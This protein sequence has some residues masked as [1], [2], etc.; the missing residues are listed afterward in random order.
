MPKARNTPDAA[1]PDASD[2]R[3]PRHALQGVLA[4]SSQVTYGHVGN[5]A[6]RFVLERMGLSAWAVPTV[7]LAQHPGHRGGGAQLPISAQ[8]I[9]GLMD[10]LSAAGRLAHCQGVIA[11]YLP[12]VDQARALGRALKLVHAQAPQA[13]VLFDP[14]FGDDGAWGGD[15][16]PKGSLYLPEE[17]PTLWLEE[18]LPQADYLTPNRFELSH[19]TGVEVLDPPTALRACLTLVE[20]MGRA[21]QP[22]LIA[23]TSVPAGQG[24][25]ATV[26]SQGPLEGFVRTPR[27]K[28]AP[29][30]TGDCFAALL[31]AHLLQEQRREEA[32]ARAVSAVYEL[33]EIALRMRLDELPLTAFQ[34]RL[35]APKRL[36][37]FEA[38]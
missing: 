36:F 29:H 25:L 13:P 38:L 8:I 27:L 26:L 22:P 17:I 2:Q 16:T 10:D 9:D 7:L 12:S 31:F 30:G 24:H 23:V 34:D 19:L 32:L 21:S 18:F 28:E 11:G 33:A 5:S 35:I 14:V 4:L 1:S 6:A 15:G 37:E 20:K 3:S